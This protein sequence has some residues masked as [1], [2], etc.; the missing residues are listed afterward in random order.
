MKKFLIAA[1]L[2]ALS[3]SSVAQADIGVDARQLDQ[4]R[5]IDAGK[6]SGKLS[7]NER[8]IL[9]REQRAIKAQEARLRVRGANLSERDERRI[10]ALLDQAQAHINRLKRNGV[11][12]RTGVHI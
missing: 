12:G 10:N 9:D 11:R 1:A 5:Q 3:L 7:R 4:Q 6:R 2:G 8:A